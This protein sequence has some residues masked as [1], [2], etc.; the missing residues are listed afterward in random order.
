[1][2]ARIADDVRRAVAR[3]EQDRQ[4]NHAI[5]VIVT[6][7]AGADLQKL[8]EHGLKVERA[9]ENIHAVSGTATPAALERIASLD[10]VELIEYD[11][12]VAALSDAIGKKA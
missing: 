11:G 12:T 9:F 4:P 2:A 3:V 6:C 1:M 10:C 5:P 7:A 8:A